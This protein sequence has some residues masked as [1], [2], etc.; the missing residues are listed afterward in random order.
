METEWLEQALE[1]LSLN[2]EAYVSYI[3]QIL[4]EDSATDEKV[5]AIADFISAATVGIEIN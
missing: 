2:D 3:Q 4:E 5:D 1:K